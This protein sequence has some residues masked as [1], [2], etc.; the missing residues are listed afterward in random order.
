MGTNKTIVH[1]DKVAVVV[2]DEGGKWARW[3][4]GQ[5]LVIHFHDQTSWDPKWASY[6]GDKDR[7]KAYGAYRFLSGPRK[8]EYSSRWFEPGTDAVTVRDTMLAATGLAI[9]DDQSESENP[10]CSSC[11]ST[12]EDVIGKDL[13]AYHKRRDREKVY[14]ESLVSEGYDMK[15]WPVQTPLLKPDEEYKYYDAEGCNYVWVYPGGSRVVVCDG[16]GTMDGKMMARRYDA[17][18]HEVAKR[19]FDS[20]DSPV[21]AKNSLF[22][23]KFV[24]IPREQLLESASGIPIAPKKNNTGMEAD[25]ATY[26]KGYV[27]KKQ[28]EIE[29][30]YARDKHVTTALVA[31]SIILIAAALLAVAY[32]ALAAAWAWVVANKWLVIGFVVFLI[33]SSVPV[34]YVV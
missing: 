23:E 16:M 11:L 29:A 7:A 13:I 17:A 1:A 34:V 4:Y 33:V 26:G 22:D 25:Y 32:F 15:R 9:I 31:I 8:G 19:S 12:V 10:N 3:D 24:Y 5:L 21:H 18:G 27:E 14:A 20:G 6:Q 30:K 2:D 28:A